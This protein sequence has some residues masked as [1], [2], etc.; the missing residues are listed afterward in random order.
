MQPDGRAQCAHMVRPLF[1][2]ALGRSIGYDVSVY[3]DALLGP[4]SI[5]GTESSRSSLIS[6]RLP[7]SR[8]NTNTFRTCTRRRR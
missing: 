5:F 4:P 7:P 2:Q 1:D 6:R 8:A 3:E